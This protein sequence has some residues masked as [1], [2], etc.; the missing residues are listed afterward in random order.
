MANYIDCATNIFPG[1]T[2]VKNGYTVV[3][4][5]VTGHYQDEFCGGGGVSSSGIA[6]GG[7]SVPNNVSPSGFQSYLLNR[8][9]GPTYTVWTIAAT[10]V[11]QNP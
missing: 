11:N 1:K 6:Q 2:L 9:N 5:M 10:G 4:A 8:L 7:E 3:G